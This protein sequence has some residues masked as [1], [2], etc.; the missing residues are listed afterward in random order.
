NVDQIKNMYMN[1]KDEDNS[2]FKVLDMYPKIPKTVKNCLSMMLSF[3]PLKRSNSFKML[4]DIKYM[5]IINKDDLIELIGI[6]LG[7]ELPTVNRNSKCSVD[8]DEY[9]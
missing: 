9:Q 2:S 3:V 1:Y 5:T 8:H 7:N 4:S 6:D